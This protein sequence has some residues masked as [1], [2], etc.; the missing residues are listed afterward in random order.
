[1]YEPHCISHRY[2]LF[3][4]FSSIHYKQLKVLFSFGFTSLVSHYDLKL[5][6]FLIQT[7]SY[8]QRSHELLNRN[9]SKTYLHNPVPGK[10]FLKLASFLPAVSSIAATGIVCV[11][12]SHY[13]INNTL[14]DH[15]TSAIKNQKGRRGSGETRFG[16]S[17]LLTVSDRMECAFLLF[18]IKSFRQQ[19]YHFVFTCS[20]ILLLFVSNASGHC[21]LKYN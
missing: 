18:I 9:M 4:E 13:R 6:F 11:Y 21:S 16:Y 14:Y 17:V 12:F 8:E 19:S 10:H 5:V 2:C 20:P 1:M 3:I 15:A 7:K